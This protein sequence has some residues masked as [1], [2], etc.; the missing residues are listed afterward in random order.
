MFQYF[1]EKLQKACDG[2]LTQEEIEAIRYILADCALAS[3]MDSEV[4]KEAVAIC[5]EKRYE[6]TMSTK[7]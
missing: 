4:R 1:L 2:K 6:V 7:L 5:E 3:C